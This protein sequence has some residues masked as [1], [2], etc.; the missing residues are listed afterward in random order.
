MCS[1]IS[2]IQT[3]QEKYVPKIKKGHFCDRVI[4]IAIRHMERCSVSLIIGE[5]QIKSSMRCHLTR[6]TMAISKHLQQKT[7]ERVWR[8][9]SPPAPLLR[10]HISTSTREKSMETLQRAKHKSTL[11]PSCPK[12][13]QRPGQNQHF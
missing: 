2:K 13:G 6:V 5:R 4:Q 10:I 1:S 8:E 3:T 11:E 7:R 12:F 9:G